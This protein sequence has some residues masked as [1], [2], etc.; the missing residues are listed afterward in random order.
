MAYDWRPTATRAATTTAERP[1]ARPTRAA[2]G[3]GA[4]GAAAKGTGIGVADAVEEFI[5]EAED[6][7][8]LNR[9]GRRYRP[10]ALR[11][12]RGIL[13]HHVAA[14][15]GGMRL[16]DVR[17]RDAQAL[18]NRL[19]EDGLSVSRI[20][21]VVSGLRALFGWAIDRGHVE[22]SPATGLLIPRDEPEWKG[23]RNG[24]PPRE[25][26]PERAASPWRWREDFGAATRYDEEDDHKPIAFLPERI[27][28]F[29]LRIVVVLFIFA[30]L[31]SVAESF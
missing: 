28:S 10:S 1:V 18:V 26:E 4:R 14:D 11:D 23:D 21:S 3:A 17:R 2:K 12:L 5:A 29:V 27:L 19:A 20:Q 24:H 8:A 16:A 6:G 9:S 15:L 13:R 31:A 7:R 25:N 30:A 22:L